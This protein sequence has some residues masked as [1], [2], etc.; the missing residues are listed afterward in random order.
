MTSP[1]VIE[2]I[3]K[4][5]SGSSFRGSGFDPLK[6]IFTGS[7]VGGEKLVNACRSV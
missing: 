6:G 1:K 3:V 5:K 4:E 7:F 2:P